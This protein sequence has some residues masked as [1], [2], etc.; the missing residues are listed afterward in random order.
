MRMSSRALAALPLAG[1][2]DHA[3]ESDRPA[4]AHWHWQASQ[5][6]QCTYYSLALGLGRL[7]LVVARRA[8]GPGLRSACRAACDSYDAGTR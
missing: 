2:H 5:S 4:R 6:T 3:P 8:P 1:W 7:R